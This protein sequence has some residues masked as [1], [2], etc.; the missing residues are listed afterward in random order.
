MIIKYPTG[1]YKNVLPSVPSDST[2]V[3]FTISN[4]LPPRSSLVFPK[5][6]TALEQRKLHEPV[7]SSDASQYGALAFTITKAAPSNIISG[8]KA[9]DLGDVIEFEDAATQLVAPMLVSLATEVRHDLNKYDLSA[10]GVDQ[11]LQDEFLIEIKKG[12]EAVRN[13]LNAAVQNRADSMIEI[14]RLN[15]LRSETDKTRNA[16]IYAKEAMGASDVLDRTIAKLT[17]ELA[18]INKKIDDEINRANTFAE[19]ADD[20]RL[21]YLTLC[22]LVN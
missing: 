2:S 17:E 20:L 1:F 13:N 15:K 3:T 10:V 7:K 4:S 8:V 22:R 5:L 11:E 14:D 16:S 21:K 6:P 12:Q 19:T 9:V 18:V